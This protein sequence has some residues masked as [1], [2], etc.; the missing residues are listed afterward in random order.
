MRAYWI[1][2]R[3]NITEAEYEAMYRAQGGVCAICKA[4]P[5]PGKKLHIDHDHK[6]DS[7]RGLLCF[8][9]NAPLGAMGDSPEVL[10]AAAD[11]IERHRKT[12]EERT[13]E[14][15]LIPFPVAADASASA[16]K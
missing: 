12:M 10:R 13:K 11:Y 6:T 8:K 14:S 15:N 4:V 1:K 7:L 5:K 16:G 9:C 3:Y 2:T